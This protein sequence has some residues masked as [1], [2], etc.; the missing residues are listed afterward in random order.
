[1]DLMDRK[2]REFSGDIKLRARQRRE[3]LVKRAKSKS[4]IK[5][6]EKELVKMRRKVRDKTRSHQLAGFACMQQGTPRSLDINGTAFALRKAASQ[7][8]SSAFTPD[9]LMMYGSTGIRARRASVNQVARRQGGS[10]ARQSQLR[11]RSHASTLSAFRSWP[12]GQK[13]VLILYLIPNPQE[14]GGELVNIRSQAR[15]GP[16]PLYAT[17]SLVLASPNLF[18]PQATMALFPI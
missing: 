2:W 3:A 7:S 11:R 9:S 15:V 12:A 10:S 14:S 4:E 8:V 1:M 13:L 17:N 16:K 18:V 5:A 6:M